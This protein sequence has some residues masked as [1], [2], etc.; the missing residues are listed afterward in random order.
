VHALAFDGAWL[1]GVAERRALWRHYCPPLPPRADG[2]HLLALWH[3]LRD[4][5]LSWPWFER[6]RY[7]IRRREAP[8]AGERLTAIVTDLALQP[9]T[10]GDAALAAL[11]Y[12]TKSAL[13]AVAQPVLLLHD[14]DDV[15][16]QWTARIEK[17]LGRGTIAPRPAATAERA[18]TVLTHFESPSPR[19]R[20]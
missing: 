13:D 11:E 10:Y 19:S 3:R 5:E 17:R 4:Q 6:G 2:T 20:K 8:L 15:R 16:Y 18:R 9:A 1:L 7:G 14:A 12:D